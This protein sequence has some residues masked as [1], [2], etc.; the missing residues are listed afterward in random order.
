MYVHHVLIPTAGA[1]HGQAGQAR[2]A[3]DHGDGCA[4]AG[5]G[6]VGVQGQGGGTV[7]VKGFF[8]VRGSTARAHMSSLTHSHT[9]ECASCP[10]N[11]CNSLRT[12]ARTLE[13]VLCGEKHAKKP[14][15]CAH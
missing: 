3:E 14:V 7:G 1:E 10:G 2:R 12:G 8:M 5:T 15:C 4:M 9:Q 11:A 13:Y 6:D